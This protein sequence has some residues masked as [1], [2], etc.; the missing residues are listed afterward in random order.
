[1]LLPGFG[2]KAREKRPGDEVD[3]KC[4]VIDMKLIGHDMIFFSNKSHFNRNRFA[5]SLVSKGRD[6]LEPGNSLF[7]IELEHRQVKSELRTN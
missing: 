1:M 4:E 2:A 7:R 5:L 3:A 6:F